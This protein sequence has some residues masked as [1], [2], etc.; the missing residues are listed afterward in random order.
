MKNFLELKQ[1]IPNKPWLIVGKGPSFI[2]VYD[3]LTLSDYN[4]FGLNHV[5][6]IIPTFLTSVIDLEV[7]DSDIISKSENIIIP[8]HPHTCFRPAKPGLGVLK[9][10][11]ALLKFLIKENKL[12]WYNLSTWKGYHNNHPTFPIIT[13]KFFSAEAAFQILGYLG[14]KKVFSVGLDGGK[15]YAQ[16]FYDLNLKPLTNTQPDF[17]RQFRMIDRTLKQFN[18][19]HKVL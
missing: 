3:D 8:W 13:T 9:D 2:K 11:N 19:K 5:A 10:G 1:K 16:D 18:I 6:K 14:V 15:T 17:D 4:V 12:Y 7:L